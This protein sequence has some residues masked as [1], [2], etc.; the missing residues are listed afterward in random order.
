MPLVKVT[1]D[2]RNLCHVVFN[3]KSRQR[4]ALLLL[5]ISYSVKLSLYTTM[6]SLV[7][8]RQVNVLYCRCNTVKSGIFI[9][10]INIKIQ[11]NKFIFIADMR[12]NVAASAIDD[13]RTKNM[14]IHQSVR[15]SWVVCR[16]TSCAVDE[17]PDRDDAA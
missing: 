13:E 6:T 15:A 5:A 16:R 10:L 2:L 12:G 4:P 9:V 7:N 17:G 11:L 1:A 3:C 8:C 14:N